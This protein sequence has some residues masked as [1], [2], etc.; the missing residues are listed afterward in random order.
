MDPI[1]LGLLA[2]AGQAAGAGMQSPGT[3]H[4]MNLSKFYNPLL[5]T[6]VGGD[7]ANRAVLPGL[8]Q[9]MLTTRAMGQAPSVASI[10]GN[11]ALDQLAKH[12]YARGNVGYGQT[13]GGAM[14]GALGGVQQG[15]QQV[16]EQTAQASLQEQAQNQAV[17]ATAL[18]QQRQLNDAAAAR[19]ESVLQQAFAQEGSTNELHNPATD[20]MNGAGI[21]L[22]SLGMGDLRQ[23][24]LG[25]AGTAFGGPLLGMFGMGF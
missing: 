20:F 8:L 10:Q 12:L 19:F 21:D 4:G 16:A 23:G 17:L 24:A 15:S 22:S 2:G 5:R 11:A 25:A 1:T 7:F 13:G 14:A 6:E 9:Q 3:S 18:A